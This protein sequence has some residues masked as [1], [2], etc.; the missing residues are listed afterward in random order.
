MRITRPTTRKLFA[1]VT[2]TALS[3]VAM[4]GGVFAWRTADSARGAAIVGQN[5]FQIAY[6]PVCDGDGVEPAD[7]DTGEAIPCLTL[8]GHNGQTTNVGEGYG[9]NTGDFDL[10]VVGGRVAIR[11]V[12]SPAAPAAAPAAA[13]D[14][15][16][17]DLVAPDTRGCS[18]DD[19][20]GEVRLAN[21]GEVIPPGGEGG[22]FGASLK[23][24][25]DA[26]RSCQGSIVVYRVTI[27]AENPDSATDPA[28]S[29]R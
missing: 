22:K 13:F 2:L 16:D 23:V 11:H 12:I 5:V 25:G 3:G 7:P 8:I 1:G 10:S 19:F 4:F 18:V 15:L 9:K 17:E 14:E 27:V 24:S 29:V 28:L 26:P 20:G 21:P 6:Q